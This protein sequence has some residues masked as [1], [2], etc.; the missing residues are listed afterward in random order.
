MT[1]DLYLLKD[2]LAGKT[3]IMACNTVWG[4]DKY[5]TN[6][7]LTYDHGTK[8]VACGRA[9]GGARDGS[10]E[11]MGFIDKPNTSWDLVATDG[12]VMGKRGRDS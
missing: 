10:L 9:F 12:G 7:P 4:N 3:F 8:K 6:H 2:T 5:D 11:F 1:I